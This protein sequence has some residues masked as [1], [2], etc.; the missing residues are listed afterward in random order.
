MLVFISNFIRKG[1]AE[2]F[3]STAPSRCCD[4]L[5]LSIKLQQL[6]EWS[7]IALVYLYFFLRGELH[8][9]DAWK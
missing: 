8:T 3:V 6:V 7:N 9:H 5:L 2:V 4:T 1:N